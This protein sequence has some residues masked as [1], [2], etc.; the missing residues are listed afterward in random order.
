[1]SFAPVRDK[2]ADINQFQPEKTT[3]IYEYVYRQFKCQEDVVGKVKEKGL[4]QLSWNIHTPQEDFVMKSVRLHMPFRIYC[5]SN[6]D[7][8]SMRLSDRNPACNVAISSSPMK[9]FTDCQL[10][11]NGNIFSIQP[12]RFQTVLDTCYQSRDETSYI[13]N[14]SL[15]PNANRNLKRASESSGTFPVLPGDPDAEPEYVQIEDAYSV[16]SNSA[17]DL[18]FSN[19]G[20]NRRV[21]NFQTDLQ[22]SA[23]YADT[24]VISYLDVGP[25]MS[26]VR[27]TVKGTPQYN[28]AVPHVKDFSLKLM[29]DQRESEFDRQRGNAYD[30]E[31]PGRVLASS[32]LEFATPCNMKHIGETEMSDQNWAELFEFEL[33]ERPF[34][35]VCY[36]KMGNDLLDT[37]KLRYIDHQYETSDPFS[38]N[39]PAVSGLGDKRLQ[40][41]SVPI[42]INSRLLE[43][44]SK[45]YVWCEL[46]HEY[47]KSFFL[48]GTQRCCKIDGL[49]L[50][51]NNRNDLLFEPS[52]EMLYDN[53]KRLTN[54][55]WGI[56][57]WRKCPIYC[58]DPSTF[59]LDA[60]KT[61]QA[62]M[63]HYE[64]DFNVRPT[65]LL[66]EELSALNNTRSLKAMGYAEDLDFNTLDGNGL[67]IA[68]IRF[69]VENRG[70]FNARIRHYQNW[71]PAPN[72]VVHDQGNWVPTTWAEKKR[73]VDSAT[74][75]FAGHQSTSW[76]EFVLARNGTTVVATDKQLF[77][78]SDNG[79]SLTHVWQ[80]ILENR[81]LRT[82]HQTA[83]AGDNT[84][85]IMK[86]KRVLGHHLRLDGFMWGA[87]DIRDQHLKLIDLAGGHGGEEFFLMFIPESNLFTVTQDN[88]QRGPQF[89]KTSISLF[90]H[91]SDYSFGEA[92]ADNVCWAAGTQPI[93]EEGARRGFLTG[94]VT[95]INQ[96]GSVGTYDF[97]T[98]GPNAPAGQQG[99]A[100]GQRAYYVR[101]AAPQAHP[102]QPVITGIVN[103][104]VQD[105]RRS[106]AANNLYQRAGF[107]PTRVGDNSTYFPYIRQVAGAP[108]NQEHLRW[109]AFQLTADAHTGAN[110]NVNGLFIPKNQNND[111]SASGFPAG[112]IAR[113]EAHTHTHHVDAAL[114]REVHVV[115]LALERNN[116]NSQTYANY[117]DYGQTM[118]Q[119]NGQPIDAG[120]G[121][122]ARIGRGFIASDYHDPEKQGN[123]LKFQA[124]I[125]Y[126]FGQKRYIIERDGQML[127]SDE[128]YPSIDIDRNVVAGVTT[129][130]AKQSVP[131]LKRSGRLN[132]QDEFY[133]QH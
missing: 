127:K 57:T 66:I 111:D 124:N 121:V 105:A 27:K 17:F 97:N 18:T 36:V 113:Y 85:E 28:T 9:M 59:G 93:I 15:K 22:G 14:M 4:T 100:P 2:K 83:V 12:G 102:N 120:Y 114:G 11:M 63:M 115:H 81:Y 131:V 7:Y 33:R 89:Q 82:H 109:V 88:Y 84:A 68:T 46:A 90:N 45:I 16:T 112:D 64:W 125:L 10:I 80:G 79:K 41:D 34:L 58:F 106:N 19:P 52:Q 1:M 128:E 132:Q 62:Q 51:I 70:Y 133:E 92:A 72:D 50:R 20:F 78:Q 44:A 23:T 53:F 129:F 29:L 77:V 101:V 126:E 75:S 6:Q 103:S 117:V 76:F 98:N 13:S 32:L 48:G 25:F 54:N 130:G 108:N 107:R 21:A 56:S 35:E 55:P 42:R 30:E 95:Q 118:V 116:F 47:K 91:L 119:G 65:E 5:K 49:H 74:Q 3:P 43:V 40:V 31:W 37:Y 123:T 73:L 8:V 96:D 67:V 104:G 24:D 87:V 122:E 61:G 99:V 60:Y 26:K 38:F 71:V 94:R 86:V 39:F 110:N 69:N